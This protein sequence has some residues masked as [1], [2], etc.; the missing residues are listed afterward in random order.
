MYSRNIFKK[1]YKH[2]HIYKCWNKKHNGVILL[3]IN[4]NERI[5]TPKNRNKK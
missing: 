2:F 4:E 3:K 1:I 5:S